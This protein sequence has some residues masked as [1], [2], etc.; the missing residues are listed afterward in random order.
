MKEAKGETRVQLV[1]LVS[2]RVFFLWQKIRGRIIILRKDV[3]HTSL[4]YI[5]FIG[6]DFYVAI[7]VVSS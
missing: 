5:A 2:S 1:R 7:N 6:I 3:T 4:R